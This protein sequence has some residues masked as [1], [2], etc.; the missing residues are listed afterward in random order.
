M[1]RTI[2]SVPSAPAALP[3][4]TAAAILKMI[5][6]GR[7]TA[8]DANGRTVYD[9]DRVRLGMDAVESLALPPLLETATAPKRHPGVETS[10]PKRATKKR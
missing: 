3:G 2:I 5:D 1:S 6:S 7:L 9:L 4:P 10:A 8:R